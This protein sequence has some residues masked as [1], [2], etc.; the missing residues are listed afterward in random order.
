MGQ[1]PFKGHKNRCGFHQYNY[2]KEAMSIFGVNV[3]VRGVL[4]NLKD[5]TKKK[6]E[7]KREL[8]FEYSKTIDHK[9]VLDF[10]QIWVVKPCK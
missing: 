6:K 4:G 3:E 1:T 2:K 5:K 9:S 10:F 8:G 7:V